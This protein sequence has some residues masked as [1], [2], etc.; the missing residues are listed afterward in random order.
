MTYLGQINKKIVANNLRSCDC[1]QLFVKYHNVFLKKLIIRHDLVYFLNC[2]LKYT[3]RNEL[4]IYI[5]FY[6]DY[7]KL[8]KIT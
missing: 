3:R 7:F 6:F 8:H 4:Q 5:W 2:V 1:E